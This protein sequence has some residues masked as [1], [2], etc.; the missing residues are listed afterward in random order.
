MITKIYGGPGAGKTT[1]LIK[2]IEESGIPV[3]RIGYCS[4]KK[5]AVEEMKNRMIKRGATDED[6]R[7]FRTIHSMNFN[8]LGIKMDQV[9]DKKLKEFCL[10]YKFKFSQKR[11]D[12]DSIPEN[13][14]TFDDIMY[15]Q[16]NRDRA[17]FRPKD[18]IHPKMRQHTALYINFRNKYFEWMEKHDYIDFLGMIERGIERGIIPPVDLLCIDEWQDLTPLQIHQVNMWARNIRVSYHAGDDDQCINQWAGAKPQ[19]F[20]DME[21]DKEIILEES[22]RLPSDVLQLS[23]EVILRNVNRKKK[24]FYTKKNKG[25]IYLKPLPVICDEIKKLDKDSSCFFLVRNNFLKSLLKRDLF[26]YGIPIDGLTREKEAIELMQTGY[27]KKYFNAKDVDI[28]TQGSLFPAKRYFKRGSKAGIAKLLK[29]LFPEKGYSF[30][31]L[32]DKGLTEYFFED[33]YNKNVSHLNMENEEMI[34]ILKIFKTYGYEFNS[35]NVMSIHEAK[36]REA[37]TVVLLPDIA[38]RSALDEEHIDTMEAE[39]NVWYTGITRARERLYMIS[40]RS[41]SGNYTHI[42]SVFRTFTIKSQTP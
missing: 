21:F 41:Y 12:G 17:D 22:F 42:M 7:Y 28:L 6:L 1:Y 35:V 10:E 32:V 39:R 4:F 19:G 20:L 2:T 27:D 40:D 16:M 23:Q 13:D 15:D 25:G 38:R 31:Q 30:K 34:Y 11:L 37:D 3:D 18:F 14:K 8:L 36:G 29:G 33:L 26:E 5:D 9:A 24:N